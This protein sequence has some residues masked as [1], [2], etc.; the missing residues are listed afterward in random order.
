MSDMMKATFCVGANRDGEFLTEPS[1]V[2]RRGRYLQAV[3]CMNIEQVHF[4]MHSE[5]SDF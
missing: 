2:N 1:R 3:M 5:Q 4:P